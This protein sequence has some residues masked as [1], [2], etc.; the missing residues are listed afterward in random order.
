MSPNPVPTLRQ[1]ADAYFEQYAGRD[2]SRRHR[3]AWWIARFGDRPA[4][5]LTDD[6]IFE[7]H[8]KSPG[9]AF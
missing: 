8:L 1:L 5:S 4:T 2:F 7:S 3:L 6:E 9:A